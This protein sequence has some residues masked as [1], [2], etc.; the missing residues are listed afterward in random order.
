M[1]LRGWKGNNANGCSAPPRRCMVGI[2]IGSPCQARRSVRRPVGRLD[3]LARRT[4]GGPAVDR[5]VQW[6]GCLGGMPA[7]PARPPRATGQNRRPLFTLL[8]PSGQLLGTNRAPPP[9]ARARG[10]GPGGGG[11][12]APR[13]RGVGAR[14]PAGGAAARG[15]G[16][17][18]GGC[19]A[20]GAARGAGR[21]VG[22]GAPPPIRAK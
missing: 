9:A 6:T 12:A 8:A 11:G 1:T 21:G 5:R 7:P 10:G 22:A 19:A 20:R 4:P 2:L 16:G 17:C 15:L 3:G 18:A 13:G 14:G